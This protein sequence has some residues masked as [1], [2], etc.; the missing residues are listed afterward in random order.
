VTSDTRV[1]GGSAWGQALELSKSHPEISIQ[2]VAQEGLDLTLAV[3][4]GQPLTLQVVEHLY[5]LPK[6][7]NLAPMPDFIAPSPN[8]LQR[9][10]NLHGGNIFITRSF[11][12]PP[13]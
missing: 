10:K 2:T 3:D 1:F 6:I 7:P 11:E 13:R 9:R 4:V 12:F 5:G 8:T